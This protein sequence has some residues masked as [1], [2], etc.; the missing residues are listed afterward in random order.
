MEKY[1]KLALKE[2]QKSF[3]KEEIPVGAI[4]VKDNKV[5][6]RA[7]N[8]KEQKKDPTSHAEILAIQKAAKKL[9]D[10]RLTGCTMY[11]TLEPCAMCA[12][13]IINAR[14]DKIVYG[15][16]DPKEGGACGEKKVKS[17]YYE[18]LPAAKI[19]KDSF[20]KLR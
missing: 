1:L 4:I 17:E 9:K 13:A 8:L 18:F 6:A 12:G 19:L 16:K 20:Q 14:L 10:W 15:S 7:H 3:S 5:I 11:I 2:A